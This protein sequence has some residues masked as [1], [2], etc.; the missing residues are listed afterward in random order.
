MVAKEP[1]HVR[2]DYVLAWPLSMTMESGGDDEVDYEAEVVGRGRADRV[3]MPVIVQAIVFLDSS[4]PCGTNLYTGEYRV[5]TTFGDECVL[6]AW[7]RLNMV[8]AKDFN[9]HPDR[10]A[11]D[12][13]FGITWDYRD[14]AWRLIL[15]L[16]NE[17]PNDDGAHSLSFSWLETYWRQHDG[18]IDRIEEEARRSS[19]F[20]HVL[21]GCYA[22]SDRPDVAARIRQASQERTLN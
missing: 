12:V 9:T 15:R 20:R 8:D 16:I 19:R 1:E 4:D 11:H 13:L 22:P 6:D 18:V 3:L 10:W 7:R 21:R 17:A 5:L 14:D 2:D